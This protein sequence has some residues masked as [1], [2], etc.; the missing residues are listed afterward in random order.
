MLVSVTQEDIDRGEPM[1]GSRCPVALAIKRDYP[2]PG[3]I[4]VAP[5]RVWASVGPIVFELRK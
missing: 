4:M 3:K 1:S 2:K 5:S